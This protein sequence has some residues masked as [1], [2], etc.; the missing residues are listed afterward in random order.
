MTYAKIYIL[1]LFVLFF[2]TGSYGQSHRKKIIFIAGTDSHGKGEHEHNGGSTILAKRL[3]QSIP[4]TDTI[5]CRNGW[6][7]DISVLQ[8]AAA[9][10]IYSDGGGDHMIIAH[11]EEL[12]SLAAKG[13]GIVMIHFTLE[14]PKGKYGDY[15]LQWIGGY[16][17]T[18][19]S[20][21]P[22]WTASFQTFP[23]HPIAHGVMPFVI[24][25]EWYYHMRFVDGMK[26][27]TPIL[28]VL[29]PD[30][31]LNR[32]EGTHS[33]NPF[34]R[35]EILV[36][37]EPQTVA[38]AFD[39]PNGGRGFGFTGG[40]THANWQNDNFRKLVLNAIAWTAGIKIPDNGIQSEMPDQEELNTLSKKTR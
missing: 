22:V 3:K 18:D 21:N 8:N 20:V 15:F 31:T 33:G 27:I 1:F 4:E 36:K 13:T 19:W 17:E 29:P 24:K 34:V 25:D 2:N 39:R 38:W 9:I 11:L 7:K 14:I 30:S 16:F 40:H 37:K 23:D 6:P 12:D 35:E 26:N 10:V 28:R 5:V 32:P